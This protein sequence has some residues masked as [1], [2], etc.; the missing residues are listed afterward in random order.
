MLLEI[1]GYIGTALVLT[2]MMMTSVLKLR[3]FNTLGSVISMTYAMLCGTWPVFFLNLGLVVIN[4]M[5]M[6]RL[7]KTKVEFTH[8]QAGAQ[9]KL[10][11]CFL[12]ANQADIEKYF[13]GYTYAAQED[14]QV[15]MVFDGMEA[16]GVL[17]GQ[18]QGNTF[19]SDLDYATAK[20]RDCSIAQYLFNQ[21]KEEGFEQVVEAKVSP[22]HDQYLVKMGF[23]PSE[24]TFRKAL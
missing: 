15:H 20:Y 2:S 24:G 7:R 14:T 11:T 9:D 17:I 4:V 19:V 1:F 18:R 5:Q 12:E 13:P 8:V 10:L 21:L 23:T 22:L 16:V 3:I 6:I